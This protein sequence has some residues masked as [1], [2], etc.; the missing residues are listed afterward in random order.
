MG[1]SGRDRGWRET[2]IV[3][4]ALLGGVEKLPDRPS[5]RDLLKETVKV[6]SD[7]V[8]CHTMRL[9]FFMAFNNKPTD[10]G[11]CSEMLSHQKS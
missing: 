7:T 11:K 1:G 3:D 8:R 2:P 4:A 5:G 6:S 9:D 10:R